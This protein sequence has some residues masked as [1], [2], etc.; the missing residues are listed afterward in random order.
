M[1]RLR[2]ILISPVVAVVATGFAMAFAQERDGGKPAPARTKAAA[3]PLVP[4]DPARMEK[5]LRDWEGQSEKLKTLEVSIY[6]IDIAPA[7]GDEDHYE[8]H[9]AFKNPQ[10]AYLDFKKVKL[11]TDP[12]KKKQV[13]VIGKNKKR[14]TSDFETIVCTQNEVWQYR[15]DTHQIFVFPLDKNA[16]KRALEEG[17]LP[18]L[19]NM[20]AD[21]AKARYDMIL[22]EE[23]AK[24]CLLKIVPKL[25]EDKESFSTAYVVLNSAYLLPT[26][27]LLVAPD[28]K[29]T[30]DFYLSNIQAN[31]DVNKGYFAVGDPGKP[32]KIERNPGGAAPARAEAMQPRRQPNGQAAQ[33][34]RAANVD[35]PR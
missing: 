14:V 33:R 12:K 4:P 11:A 26:R 5:L 29:S 30:K 19:F 16:R 9:A 35:Q 18:F 2:M 8:G 7:W 25:K 23:D 1:P 3:P 13:P 17:P 6:R 32:W 20:K 31:K 27:I 15:F 24:S 10:L 21:E 22:V 28:G 34:P